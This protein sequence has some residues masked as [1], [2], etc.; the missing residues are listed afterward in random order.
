MSTTC[1]L[2]LAIEPVYAFVVLVPTAD[3]YFLPTTWC[4]S[5]AAGAAAAFVRAGYGARSVRWTRWLA[6]APTAFVSG[7]VL[8]L[9]ACSHGTAFRPFS[10][11]VA[12]PLLNLCAVSCLLYVDR[13]GGSAAQRWL[14]V[15]AFVS[16]GA[17]SLQPLIS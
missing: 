16:A 17:V 4:G 7:L 10:T 2:L 11:L 8:L 3:A 9:F 14:S 5:F 15:P 12:I 6:H 1:L 13:A